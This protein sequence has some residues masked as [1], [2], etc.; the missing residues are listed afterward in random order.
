MCRKLSAVVLVVIMAATLLPMPASAANIT[1]DEVVRK[2]NAAASS[3][4]YSGYYTG[5]NQCLGFAIKLFNYIFGASLPANY[6]TID[7][8]AKKGTLIKVVGTQLGNG[9]SADALRS[10]LSQAKPGD[11]FIAGP[12]TD[13]RHSFPHA[14]IIREVVKKDGVVTSIKVYDANGNWHGVDENRIATNQEWFITTSLG[15]GIQQDRNTSAKLYRYKGYADKTLTIT[16]DPN[17]GS[18]SKITK[19]YTYSEG[20]GQTLGSTLPT[21]SRTGYTFSHWSTAGPGSSS[22]MVVNAKTEVADI[23]DKSSITLYAYWTEI[24]CNGNHTKGIFRF[25]EAVH[26]H[27]NYW[28]CS[29]CGKNFTDGSTA[30]MSSCT[31]CNP[32][33]TNGHTW[34]SWTTTKAPSC[35]VAG[36]RKRTC[37]RCGQTETET[38]AALSHNYQKISSTAA[39]DVYACANCKD[40]YRV[41]KVKW[42]QRPSSESGTRSVY[43]GNRGDTELSC[44]CLVARYQDGRLVSLTQEVLNIPTGTSKS[45]STS[46]PLDTGDETWKVF[47]LDDQSCV[48]LLPSLEY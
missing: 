7:S 37:S 47:V 42:L 12:P 1:E 36:S 22:G 30:K 26:P 34:G 15:K 29:V 32:P 46:I 25:Y 21:V 39:Y 24:N 19:T 10:L 33:C 41:D 28:Q 14:V 20:D 48:P 9:Y 44:R 11:L 27:Y 40:G 45:I 16:F 18:G 3:P 43:V 38:V 4:Q 31:I 6:A 5:N 35:G 13:G 2:L 8:Y 17:G 23:T